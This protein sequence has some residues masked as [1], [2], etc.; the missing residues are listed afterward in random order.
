MYD[1]IQAALVLVQYGLIT[2]FLILLN[3]SCLSFG[4]LS[5]ADI[6]EEGLDR[7]QCWCVAIDAYSTVL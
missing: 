7:M 4:L 5:K 3:I 1:F 6:I 2:D